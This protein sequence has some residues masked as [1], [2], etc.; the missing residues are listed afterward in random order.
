VLALQFHLEIKA[1]G[2]QSL[3]EN[4][5][6]ELQKADFVQDEVALLEGAKQCDANNNALG[7]LLNWLG[8]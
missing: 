6:A 5:K 7:K 1:G 8:K 4:A 3:I 2:I